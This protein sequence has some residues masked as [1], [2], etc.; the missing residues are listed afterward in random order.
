MVK[1]IKLVMSDIDGTI[2]DDKHKIDSQLKDSLNKMGAKNI[3][4]ILTS[5]RSP[6]GMYEIAR[7]LDII[8]N[9]L[10]C[11]NGA[12]ILKDSFCEEYVPVYNQELHC[13]DVKILIDVIKNK[14]PTVSISL[15]SGIEWY[16]D[17]YD[18]WIET[19]MAI[20]AIKPIKK[21]LQMLLLKENIP[22]HK[23]LFIGETLA[24]QQLQECCE[25]LKLVNSS[26][27]LSKENYLEVT[28][29]EVSKEK[30]LDVLAMYY[31]LSLENT[32]AVG[33]NFNDI[34]MLKKAGIGVAMANAPKEVKKHAVVTTASNNEN[35]VSKALAEYVL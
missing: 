22:I 6:K 19:E 24:I 20:T 21:N 25:A 3:T 35:G 23:L 29:K 18:K 31:H 28:H 11:Y 27:Y 7:E 34:P 13:E 17:E 4:F 32:L 26:F 33:D 2:L 15:Y 8:T 1:N 9:P 12:L 30:A 16:V 14:F 5:A 10:V